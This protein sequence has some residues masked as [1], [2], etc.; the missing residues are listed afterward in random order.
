[1]L[2]VQAYT[3]SATIAQYLEYFFPSDP[4]LALEDEDTEAQ[5]KAAT[6]GVFGAFARSDTSP[7]LNVI[8]D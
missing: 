6:G 7:F 4:P 1:M 2:V 5:I 8:S 3:D